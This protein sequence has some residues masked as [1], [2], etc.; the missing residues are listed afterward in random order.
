MGTSSSFGFSGFDARAAVG[1]GAG[2]S[3]R[4][5]ND[6]HAKMPPAAATSRTAMMAYLVLPLESGTPAGGTLEDG[7]LGV[8]ILIR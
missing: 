2:G 5:A 4:L 7:G 8:L 6:R 1:A 3:L